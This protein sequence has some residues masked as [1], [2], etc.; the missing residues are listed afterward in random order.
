MG[1]EDRNF[2]PQIIVVVMIQFMLYYTII[3][4]LRCDHQYIKALKVH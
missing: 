3:Y 4:I 1:E 2:K